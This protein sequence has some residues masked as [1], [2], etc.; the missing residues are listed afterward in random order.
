MKSA[1]LVARILALLVLLAAYSASPISEIRA[2]A[3]AYASELSH[4]SSALG[5]VGSCAGGYY[6]EDDT[7]N[8]LQA[9]TDCEDLLCQ[10]CG[11]VPDWDEF[12]CD[13]GLEE[14]YC[15]CKIPTIS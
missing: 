12:F 4:E 8:C 7:V 13:E 2:G 3:V 1:K 10:G 11:L 15:A 14:A 6:W 9:A 5:W